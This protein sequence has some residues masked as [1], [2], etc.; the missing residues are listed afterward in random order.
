MYIYVYMYG[1]SPPYLL[2]TFMDENFDKSSSK[3]SQVEALKNQLTK[4]CLPP[5]SL[6]SETESREIGIWNPKEPAHQGV[7]RP[8]CWYILTQLRL[9]P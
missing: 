8:L 7:P 5:F 3:E 6:K 9:R 1:E 4:V 2:H